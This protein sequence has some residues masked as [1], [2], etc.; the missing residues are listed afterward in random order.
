M[1]QNR[2]LKTD[3]QKAIATDIMQ[4]IVSGFP[5][6]TGYQVKAENI[7]CAQVKTDGTKT[8]CI[9]QDGTQGTV[10]DRKTKAKVS[11]IGC[12]CL[13]LQRRK[14][15]KKMKLKEKCFFEPE[16]LVNFVNKNG[17]TKKN[18]QAIERMRSGMWCLLWWE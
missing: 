10:G 9:K 12:H 6:R 5:S 16:E 18:I 1:Q 15:N 3:I 4:A 13:H 11:H 7:L 14:E 8:M 17:I 2:L